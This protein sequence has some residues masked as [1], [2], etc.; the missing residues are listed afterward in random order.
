[1]EKFGAKKHHKA[2]L[3]TEYLW[4]YGLSNNKNGDN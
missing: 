1:M 2:S 4:A 3:W